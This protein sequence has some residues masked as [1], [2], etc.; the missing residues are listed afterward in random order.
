MAAHLAAMIPN[1]V[2]QVHQTLNP[3]NQG[4]ANSSR[5]TIKHFNSCSPPKFNGMEGVTGLL[6]WYEGMENTF[7][8][9]ECLED[10]RVQFATSVFQKRELTWWNAVKRTRGLESAMAMPWIDFKDHMTQEFC[11]RN[12]MMKLEAE[13]WELKQDSGENLIYTTRFQELSLLVPHLVTPHSP[14]I[15]K[16]IKGLPMQI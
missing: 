14:A 11:P 3:A 2:G 5:C 15:E 13:F 4:G 10:K 16:C 9:S 6:K 7:L 1:I 12:E 8:N